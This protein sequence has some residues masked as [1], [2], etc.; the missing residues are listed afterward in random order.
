MAE[1]YP[2]VKKAEAGKTIEREYPVVSPAQPAQIGSLGYLLSPLNPREKIV[3]AMHLVFDMPLSE[4]ARQLVRC[5]RRYCWARP[6]R[7]RKQHNSISKSAVCKILQGARQKVF[8]HEK[9]AP[10]GGRKK[11]EG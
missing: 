3:L 6:V 9:F 8:W 1:I 4:I 11:Q 2:G 7:G 5:P 10:L